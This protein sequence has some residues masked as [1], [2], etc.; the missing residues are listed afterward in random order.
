MYIPGARYIE[1]STLESP[2]T[3]VSS[4]RVA[5]MLRLFVRRACHFAAHCLT[6]AATSHWPSPP[7]E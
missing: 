3:T 7:V 6:P 4:A 1:I 5:S 2:R